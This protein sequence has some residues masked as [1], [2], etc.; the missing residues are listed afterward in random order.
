MPGLGKAIAWEAPVVVTMPIPVT[1]ATGTPVGTTVFH[2]VDGDYEILSAS[3]VHEV[4]GTDGSAVTG[5][6]V[7]A[8]SGTALSGGTS[9]DVTTFN[10]KSTAATPVSKT[11]SNGGLKTTQAGR[12]IAKGS[13][14]GWV[15]TGTLT[16]LEGVCVTVVMRRV[17][18]PSF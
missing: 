7:R 14:L 3:E 13:R 4:A 10:L 11:V 18:R 16:G 2:A 9:V 15:Y 6:L 1:A 17:R 5:D 8:A 12:T